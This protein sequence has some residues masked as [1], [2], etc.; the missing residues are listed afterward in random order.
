[1]WS[2]KC[3]YASFQFPFFFKAPYDLFFSCVA[4]KW[5]IDK[6]R[7]KWE[8][9]GITAKGYLQVTA[10]PQELCFF[11]FHPFLLSKIILI[12][13]IIIHQ[14]TSE[15]RVSHHQHSKP[16]LPHL[17]PIS[18]IVSLTCLLWRAEPLSDLNSPLTSHNHF[19]CATAGGS[20]RTP[21]EDWFLGWVL[22]NVR[23]CNFIFWPSHYF[24]S[25]VS[26]LLSILTEKIKF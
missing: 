25:F 10:V 19:Y 18:S 14:P 3:I 5:W 13:G 2:K 17:L 26:Y 20:G 15:A 4:S 8:G 9:L 6:G 1:M 22:G 21:S 11:F 16:F 23:K 24:D 7:R 12:S